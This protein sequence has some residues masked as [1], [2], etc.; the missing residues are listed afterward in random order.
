MVRSHDGYIDDHGHDLGAAPDPASL[1]DAGLGTD[2]DACAG[3]VVM[4]MMLRLPL[5]VNL[6]TM[7][8]MTI[9]I[10]NNSVT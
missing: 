6:T 10:N 1:A 2:S 8:V 3:A 5:L 9:I 7:L 4:A